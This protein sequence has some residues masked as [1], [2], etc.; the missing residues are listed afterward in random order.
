LT[1]VERRINIKWI[2]LKLL[3][4]LS[5][6]EREKKELG[7]TWLGC[8]IQPSDHYKVWYFWQQQQQQFSVSHF[9]R[10]A[11]CL[12]L[13]LYW[14]MFVYFWRVIFTRPACLLFSWLTWPIPLFSKVLSFTLFF[15]LRS[16]FINWIFREVFN[17]SEFVLSKGITYNILLLTW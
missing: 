4:C 17:G 2:I 13:L 5:I 7:L 14:Y 15:Q 1:L 9:E 3:T 8:L 10:A 6:N 11:I 16:K 12:G